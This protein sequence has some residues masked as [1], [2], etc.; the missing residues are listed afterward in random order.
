MNANFIKKLIEKKEGISVEFKS[1]QEELT[2]TG[3]ETIV[4]FLNTIGGYLILGVSDDGSI[5][6]V[7]EDF[8]TSIETEFSNTVNNKERINPP[9]PLMFQETY[10]ESK[11]ILYVYVPESSE[12]HKLNNKYVFERTDDGDRN[13]TDNGYALKRLYNRKSGL[14]SEDIVFSNISFEDF[15]K[16]TIAKAR[17]LTTIYSPSNNWK[18][19]SDEEIL[20]QRYFYKLDKVTGKYGYTLSALLLFG[21]KDVICGELSW[22][23]VDVLKKLKDTERFDDRF[24]CEDNLI[25]SYDSLL[26]YIENNIDMPFFLNKDG[27]TYNAVGVVV[28]EIVSNIL[29][30]REF[31]DKSPARILLFKDKI[32]SENGNSPKLFTNVD[33][34]NNE[35]FSKNSTI[36]RIFRMIGYADEVGSGFEKIKNICNEF[37]HSKPIVEDKDIFRI[38]INLLS[39]KEIE[40]DVLLNK[41]KIIDYIKSKGTITNQEGRDLLNLEKTQVINLFN[42]LLSENKIFR[43]G[44]GKATYY[45]F[46]KE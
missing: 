3:F 28:R 1:S 42:E 45:D 27:I 37:F 30:H 19:L 34:D 22:Y 7:N 12:V 11:L 38:N 33:L 36:A 43:H 8:V 29:I 35:P 15:N 20:K 40:S 41:E 32:I 44:Q 6:G 5:I 18:D 23:K 21:K 31:M 13:I 24:I 39:D 16:E 46:N 10:I 2:K 17:K 9:V 4:S 14:K 25:D 26:K